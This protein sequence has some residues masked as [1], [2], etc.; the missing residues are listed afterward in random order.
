MSPNPD[1]RAGSSASAHRLLFYS[2]KL[3]TLVDAARLPRTRWWYDRAG[4]DPT[5]GFKRSTHGLSKDWDSIDAHKNRP[6]KRRAIAEGYE[7]H[8][9]QCQAAVAGLPSTEVRK[10]FL[11]RFG[12]TDVHFL[13]ALAIG[14]DAVR[15]GRRNA[16]ALRRHLAAGRFDATSDA[17]G[18]PP[19]DPV[20]DSEARA[21]ATSPTP[22]RDRLGPRQVSLL[23][24]EVSCRS[25]P[26]AR[27][28]DTV[29]P[30][31]G[32]V[33]TH[34]QMNPLS[35]LTRD[36]ASRP[37][38]GKKRPLSPDS[39][40]QPPRSRPVNEDLDD[41]Q[42]IIEERIPALRDGGAHGWTWE[43]PVLVSNIESK[44]SRS[45]QSYVPLG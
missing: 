45:L 21:V 8:M 7:D 14:V 3:T 11:E 31:S 1:Q 19:D 38:R 15:D 23:S 13:A 28:T 34:Q 36:A 30:Q 35:Q 2:A 26:W 37:R 40:L 44:S 18:T 24:T 39:P 22:L 6:G 25:P 20:E 41:F 33:Q 29:A 42:R 12:A 43:G 10:D 9:L 4:P 27:W 17:S 16:T 5:G 32:S